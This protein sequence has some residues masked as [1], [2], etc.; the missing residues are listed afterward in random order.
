MSNFTLKSGHKKLK[1]ICTWP[2]MCW[3]K[4][5]T[6][7]FTCRTVTYQNPWWWHCHL[8][9]YHVR[10]SWPIVPA[11]L[12][13][14]SVG[15]QRKSQLGSTLGP[16]GDLHTA[17]PRSFFLGIAVSHPTSVAHSPAQ[18]KGTTGLERSLTLDKCWELLREDV[19]VKQ[20]SDVM[21]TCGRCWPLEKLGPCPTL[22]LTG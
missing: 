21:V 5:K 17:L 15:I 2:I 16:S 19:R 6:S 22:K 1:L 10:A 14:C 9:T 18:G 11:L 4:H 13:I 12:G 7:Y 20:H 3:C 8:F